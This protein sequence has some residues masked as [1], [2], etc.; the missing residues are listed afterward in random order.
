MAEFIDPNELF[1]T[2]FEPKQKHRFIMEIDGIPT[3]LIKKTTR[4]SIENAVVELPHINV[5]RYVSGKSKW[6]G[7]CQLEMWDPIVPSG[8]QIIIEWQRL[9]TE[10]IT[11]RSGYHDFYSKDVTVQVLGPVGD[12][13]ESWS[14]RGAWPKSID[15]GD[16]DWGTEA[17]AV[18]ISV[19]LQYDYPVL[20]F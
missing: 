7:E 1:Y 4:P 6:S 8:A 2:S 18:I 17:D 9:I 11:G 14:Y 19:S 13:V 3:Y 20:N 5:T 15:F 16:L 12:I 10:S